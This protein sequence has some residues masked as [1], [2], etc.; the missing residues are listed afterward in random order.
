[1]KHAVI[2][3]LLA[4]AS[5][6]AHAQDPSTIAG[7]SHLPP[8]VQAREMAAYQAEQ[9]GCDGVS[10]SGQLLPSCG[11]K[12]KP[13][14]GYAGTKNCIGCTPEQAARR[15][16]ALQAMQAQTAADEAAYQ[17]RLTP[18]EKAARQKVLADGEARSKQQ[19]D[20]QAMDRQAVQ[21]DAHGNKCGA[22]ECGHAVQYDEYTWNGSR[23]VGTGSGF[24][25]TN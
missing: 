24:A 16:A 13:Y 7:W 18:R 19:R 22:T 10:Q 23:W 5:I 25:R 1:M 17:A 20:M 15:E 9:R 12:T 14:V 11:E 4:F 3:A 2:A 8:A 21:T 6:S